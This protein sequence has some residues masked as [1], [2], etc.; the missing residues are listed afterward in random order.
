MGEIKLRE[1]QKIQTILSEK[2]EVKD[3]TST[4]EIYPLDIIINSDEGLHKFL[5]EKSKIIKRNGRKIIVLPYTFE[6]ID[7]TH[8]Y[9][10]RPLGLDIGDKV[11]MDE[12]KETFKQIL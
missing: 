10:V 4:V 9:I 12:I 11:I 6:Q 5:Q 7:S 2:H 8:S 1:K 3:C